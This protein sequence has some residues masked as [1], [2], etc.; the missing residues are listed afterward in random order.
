MLG[1]D[2]E[3]VIHHSQFSKAFYSCHPKKNSTKS[4]LI[5]PRS[6]WNWNSKLTQQKKNN[7]GLYMSVLIEN[8][9]V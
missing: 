5:Y 2:E 7:R 4:D 9:D 1:G 3:N 6:V 8:I